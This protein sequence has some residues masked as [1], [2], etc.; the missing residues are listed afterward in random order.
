[1]FFKKKSDDQKL[2][3]AAQTGDI[4]AIK[5]LLDAGA[6]VDARNDTGETAVRLATMNNQTEAV[7]ILLEA[8]ANPNIQTI[9]G[10]TPLIWACSEGYI[11]IVRQLLKHD[12]NPVI[13]NSQGYSPMSWAKEKRHTEIIDMLREKMGLPREEKP[14]YAPPQPSAHAQGKPE[15]HV[16]DEQEIARIAKKPALNREITEIFNFTA[17]RVITIVRDMRTDADTVLEKNFTDAENPAWIEN[18]ARAYED[19]TGEKPAYTPPQK[20]KAPLKLDGN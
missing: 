8:G 20:K 14:D 4:G 17:Q 12:A 15:W 16:T 10:N 9:H 2:L 1:M 11:E 18:A 7:R 19:M 5:A 6:N 13:S 3:E